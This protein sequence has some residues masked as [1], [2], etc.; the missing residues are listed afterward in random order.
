MKAL[1]GVIPTIVSLS[2][3]HREKKDNAL[4]ATVIALD[5]TYLYYRDLDKGKSRCD[6]REALLVKYWSAAAIP[7]RHIDMDLTQRCMK[8]AEYWLDPG[9]YSA[10]DIREFGIGLESV[11]NA[12]KTLLEPKSLVQRPKVRAPRREPKL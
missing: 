10:E 4:R 7:M 9:R 8:K 12:Y 6:D 3:D 5:E 2:K 11:R 1:L